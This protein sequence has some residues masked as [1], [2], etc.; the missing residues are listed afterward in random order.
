[1]PANPRIQAHPEWDER[2]CQS[3]SRRTQVANGA[4]GLLTACLILAD[5]NRPA[6]PAAAAPFRT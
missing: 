4:S 1:M 3:S 5:R 6:Q 2:L